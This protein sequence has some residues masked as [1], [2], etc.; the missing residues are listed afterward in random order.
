MKRRITLEMVL[1]KGLNTGTCDARAVREF[2]RGLDVVI[3]LIPW[4]PVEGLEFEGVPLC[5]PGQKEASDFTA[6][7]EKEG[8]K[9]TMRLRKGR[10]VSGACGQLGR[11]I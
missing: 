5:A 2:A 11:A 6:A 4:N 7:L 1:L 9:V 8:L 3:N 10:G